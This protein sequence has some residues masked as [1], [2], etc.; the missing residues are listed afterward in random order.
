[1][2]RLRAKLSQTNSEKEGLA[3]HPG[4]ADLTLKLK[5]VDPAEAPALDL[6]M[7]SK[8]RPRMAAVCQ[9]SKPK[10]AHLKVKVCSDFCGRRCTSVPKG[11]QSMLRCILEV[12][13][14]PSE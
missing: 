12:Y 11:L 3:V 1:M 13:L 4:S 8:V 7:S 9:R 10:H 5:D 6:K 2:C 14:I